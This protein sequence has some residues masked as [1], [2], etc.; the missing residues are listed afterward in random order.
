MYY[1]C[2]YLVY[3]LATAWHFRTQLP[4]HTH[5]NTT[6]H[7]GTHSEWAQVAQCM[8][9]LWRYGCENQK[10]NRKRNEAKQHT[11]CKPNCEWGKMMRMCV[12]SMNFARNNVDCFAQMKQY[13][14]QC[15]L[16]I[17]FGFVYKWRCLLSVLTPQYLLAMYAT[18]VS[19]FY[20]IYKHIS[21]VYECLVYEIHWSLLCCEFVIG[22]V[23]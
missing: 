16:I 23:W 20:Q 3:I 21:Y 8:V 13:V 14:E 2:M 15:F 12:W 19:M 7:I 5:D 10:S 1:V 17:P 22:N 4:F 6:Q 11:A 9:W 18:C